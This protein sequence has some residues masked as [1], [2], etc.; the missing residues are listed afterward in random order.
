MKTEFKVGD[1]V[2][3]D[4]EL[5]CD[6][7]FNQMIIDLNLLPAGPTKVLQTSQVAKKQYISVEVQSLNALE[8]TTLT[9][10]SIP[11]S[12]ERFSLVKRET[13]SMLDKNKKLMKRKREKNEKN[14]ISPP[15]SRASCQNHPS[16]EE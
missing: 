8:S 11:W 5:Y 1:I 6:G 4:P 12:A 2:K 3:A 16:D 13:M 9:L 14:Q 7:M 15:G 10:G